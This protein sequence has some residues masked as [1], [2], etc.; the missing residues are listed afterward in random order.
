MITHCSY[1]N[2]TI[3]TSNNSDKIYKLFAL[4]VIVKHIIGSHTEL[5][6]FRVHG[7]LYRITKKS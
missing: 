3:N 5:Y 7:Y 1:N 2:T 6:F 4:F